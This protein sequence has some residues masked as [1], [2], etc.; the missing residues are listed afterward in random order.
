MDVSRLVRISE[1]EWQLPPQ[2]GM[3]VPAIIFGDAGLVA[4]M[5]DKVLE[6]IANVAKLPGIVDAAYAMPDAHWGY[7]SALARRCGRQ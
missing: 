2:G 3:R 6:Q 7:A 1:R 5:D 4:D